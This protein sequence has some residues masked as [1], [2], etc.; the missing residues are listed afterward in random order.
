MKA[1]IIERWG[2]PEVFQVKDVEKPS[3]EPDQVLIK[4]MATSVNPVD[5]K[6]R[7]GNHKYILGSPFPITLGYDVCGEVVECGAEITQFTPGDMVIGDLDNKY[8]G[9]YGEFA[10]GHE[11]CFTLKPDD[12][13]VE[14]AATVSLVGLTALQALRNKA[15]LS[16][17]HTV[18]INGA[19]GG[20]GHVAVQIAKNLGAK[21]LA[22]A[23][24]KNRDFVSKLGADAFIDYKT[25]DILQ[26]KKK[27]DIFFDVIGNYSFL[28]TKHLLNP[29]GIYVSTL[30][31]PKILLHKL[32][33]PFTKGKKVKTILRK[34][35]QADLA[36]LANWLEQGKLKIHI[37]KTFSLDE[38][39]TAHQYAEQGRT[40]GK[41]L[42]QNNKATF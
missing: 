5:W 11:H 20:V 38:I 31:R 33:Q 4:V 34:Q 3:P 39:A 8:G 15:G 25:Q 2:T 1:A 21:V 18:L 28:K 7:R 37:D 42:I 26:L 27:V 41:V 10:V 24:E 19:S 16:S 23:S 12:V 6:Q 14:Q 30:P 40:R 17:G 13:L 9:A 29:N 32:F 36:L 35:N 22:V